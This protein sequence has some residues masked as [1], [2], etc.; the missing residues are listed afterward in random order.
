MIYFLQSGN[1]NKNE[2]A[3]E[4]K[5]NLP[6]SQLCERFCTVGTPNKEAV[7]SFQAHGYVCVFICF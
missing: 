2:G 5:C 4:G 3:P 6:L 7:K 1:R